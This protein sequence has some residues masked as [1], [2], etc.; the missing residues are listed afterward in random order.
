MVDARGRP[1]RDLGVDRGLGGAGRSGTKQPSVEQTAPHSETLVEPW[2]RATLVTGTV[3]MVELALLVVAGLFLFARPLAHEARTHAVVRHTA[4]AKPHPVRRAAAVKP[5]P[6]K[7]LARARTPVIVL[8]GNGRSGA[9][10]EEAALVKTR[11][12]P[13]ASVGNAPRG[14]ARTVVM[15]RPGYA[16]EARR[17]AHD[18]GLSNVAPLDGMRVTALHGA[19]ALIVLGTD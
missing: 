10:A 16:P 2:R 12:Y 5:K 14:S 4:A 11:G 3:A 13:V 6:R 7:L 19:K 15:Y 18:L 8:N 1:A 17:L 9:A